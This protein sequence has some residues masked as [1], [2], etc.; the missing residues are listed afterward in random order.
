MKLL[1]RV[2][3][4]MRVIQIMSM[5]QI[6]HSPMDLQQLFIFKGVLYN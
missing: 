1:M 2:Y 3:K 5:Y 6:I 4:P